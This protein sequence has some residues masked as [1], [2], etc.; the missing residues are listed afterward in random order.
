MIIDTGALGTRRLPPLDEASLNASVKYATNVISRLERVEANLVGA[1]VAPRV[2]SPAHSQYIHNFAHDAA[3]EKGV[4]ALIA[5][6]AS[7]QLSQANCV[8][9]VHS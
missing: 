6:G 5:I 1:G 4:D 9:F 2:D 7:A 8:R 3:L